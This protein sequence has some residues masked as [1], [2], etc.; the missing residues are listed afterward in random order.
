M[1]NHNFNL[2]LVHSSAVDPKVAQ[3]R[4]RWFYVKAI[5]LYEISIT[6]MTIVPFDVDLF[7]SS[8]RQDFYPTSQ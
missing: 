5:D 8:I 4:L 7:L 1:K 6:Q 3:E 2:R